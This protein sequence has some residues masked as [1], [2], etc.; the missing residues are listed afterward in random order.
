[1]KHLLLAGS[2][3][4]AAGAASAQCTPNPLY[5][6]SLYGIW[7]DTT[8]NFAAG[9]VGQPYFQQIDVIVPQDAGLVD[10]NFSGV[11]LDSIALTSVNGLPPGLTYGCN[12]HT[13]APC[14]YITSQQGCAVISGTP[15]TVGVYELTLVVTAYANLFG[16]PVPVDQEFGGYRIEVTEEEVGILEADVA[17]LQRVQNVPNPFSTTTTIE[18]ALA[19]AGEVRVRVFS[20]VGEELWSRTVAGK[21]GINKVPFERGTLQDGVYLYKVETGRDAYTGR[22]VLNR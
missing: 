16:F 14:S 17:G 19:R 6:D 22:M 20:L 11:L 12:S 4:L 1:M 3:I 7:P 8:D 2:F 21:A 5:A 10:P 15:T 18:F 13:S 9:I